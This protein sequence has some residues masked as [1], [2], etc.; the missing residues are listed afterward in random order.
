MECVVRSC[1]HGGMMLSVR[2]MHRAR[3]A[4]AATPNAPPL[5]NIGGRKKRNLFRLYTI[6]MS[7][8]CAHAMTVSLCAYYISERCNQYDYILIA[9]TRS[10]YR[11]TALW[12]TCVQKAAREGP[13]SE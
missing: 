1:G 13:C 4:Y 5:R 12:I 3:V 7:T 9:F 8:I 6:E 2:G 10:E 11:R